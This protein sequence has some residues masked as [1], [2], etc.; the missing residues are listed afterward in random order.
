MA[1]ECCHISELL[2]IVNSSI[3]WPY[4][5]KSLVGKPQARSFLMA[6]PSLGDGAEFTLKSVS[7]TIST[8]SGFFVLSEGSRFL[9]AVVG[10]A[11]L[12]GALHI[13]NLGCHVTWVQ[14]DRVRAKPA[15]RNEALCRA[16]AGQ[17]YSGNQLELVTE[18]A[19]EASEAEAV[20]ANGESDMAKRMTALEALMT[21]MA[22]SGRRLE[23][24]FKFTSPPAAPSGPLPGSSSQANQ[25]SAG[26]P[27]VSPGRPP[28]SPYQ[29]AGKVKFNDL[30]TAATQS[31]FEQLRDLWIGSDEE[32]ESEDEDVPLRGR[33]RDERAGHPEGPPRARRPD[34]RGAGSSG[35]HVT[36]TDA[37]HLVQLET[38]RVLQKMQKRQQRGGE[39]SEEGSSD[40]DGKD[41]G[42]KSLHKMHAQ[43]RT[44]P[45]RAIAQYKAFVK[46]QLGVND[47]TQ[48]WEYRH[49]S[50]KLKPTFGRMRGLWRC[51]Y[52]GSEILEHMARGNH[53]L[54][55][56]HLVQMLKA[57]HQA[58]LDKG[59]WK[60]A[61]LLMPTADPLARV[62]F[63]GNES[64]MRKIHTF[65]KALSQL[66]EKHGGQPKKQEEDVDAEEEEEVPG[67]GKKHPKKKKN[68]Q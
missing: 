37:G 48:Y 36:A 34:R 8:V 57:L 10:I 68:G 56:G 44:N 59:Q 65:G 41:G 2:E 5:H 23:Q 28:A 40:D 52:I 1:I 46:E 19:A 14:S 54:A 33:M 4:R 22:E 26:P 39:D 6:T 66:K 45:T 32:N 18:S 38:L 27:T 64:E 11:C 7:D 15:D 58:A 50:E 30:G 9:I 63:G 49:W 61:S 21:S 60:H 35:D 13:E 31:A 55:E 47:P 62:D 12:T 25:A 67:A 24:N 43:L 3:L 53:Q 20:K 16:I 51:H 17:Y 29:V 42:F